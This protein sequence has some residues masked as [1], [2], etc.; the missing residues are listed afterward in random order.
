MKTELIKA[1]IIK[2]DG[3]INSSNHLIL[4]R[5]PHLL[6]VINALTDFLPTNTTKYER[7]FNISHDLKSRSECVV[8]GSCT[9]FLG[10][11]GYSKYCS[12]KC[13]NLFF[14]KKN[15]EIN[16]MTGISIFQIRART[17]SHN[18]KK[19]NLA[20][21]L[22]NYQESAIK[23]SDTRRKINPITGLTFYEESNRKGRVKTRKTRELNGHWVSL[24]EKTDFE[25]YKRKVREITVLQPIEKLNNFSLRG[26]AD[27][28]NMNVYQLDHKF[29]IYE[30]FK[31]GILPDIIGHIT[32]LHFIPW[33]DN[34][35]KSTKCSITEEELF[36]YLK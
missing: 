16:P 5:L 30:G 31:R 25:K 18:R 17:V 13:K 32:N 3:T 22:T 33:L 21:G 15:S 12:S 7:L 27:C 23:M 9:R 24:N 19:I 11:R 1:N 26:R 14:T 29:S 20:T 8:C 34:S 28:N 10:G 4:K 35:A 2:E 36:S 6:L